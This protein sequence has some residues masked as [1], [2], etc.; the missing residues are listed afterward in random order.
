MKLQSYGYAQSESPIT[1]IN[2]PNQQH[3][4]SIDT[5]NVEISNSM[6]LGNENFS[7]AGAQLPSKEEKC[8]I[9]SRNGTPVAAASSNSTHNL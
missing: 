8:K 2:G 6:F 4:V 3:S 1:A 5:A 7:I 9:A